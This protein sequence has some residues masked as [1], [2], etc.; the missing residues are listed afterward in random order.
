DLQLR[1]LQR[2]DQLFADALLQAL[3]HGDLP[4][5]TGY[6]FVRLGD[7]EAAHVDIARSKTTAQHVQ[8]LI[9]LKDAWCSLRHD[10]VA[11]FKTGVHA[12]EVEALRELPAGL[13]DRI[14]E[15]VTI[16]FGHDIKGRHGLNPVSE[17]KPYSKLVGA[18]PY[19]T[20]SRA[21]AFLR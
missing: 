1:P 17:T 4:P 2:G 6:V 16:D 18:L 19:D 11:Q 5:R 7:I 8:H 21:S 15:L 10:V 14:D 9:E 12:F 3:T 20:A 13:I